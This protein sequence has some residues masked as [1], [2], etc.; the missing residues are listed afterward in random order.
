MKMN[1][2]TMEIAPITSQGVRFLVAAAHQH[3]A[4]DG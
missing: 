1:G 2:R 3:R 4:I